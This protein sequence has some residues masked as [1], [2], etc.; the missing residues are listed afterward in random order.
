MKLD[1]YR[2]IAEPGEIRAI[3]R[4][5]YRLKGRSFIHVNATSFGG[6]VAE[7]LHRILPIIRELDI[8]MQ[9]KVIKGS[10]PFFDMTK[11]LHNSLQGKGK[12]ITKKMWELY[13]ETNRRNAKKLDLE[14]DCVLIHDPQPAGLI[15]SRK[16]GVWIWRCHID[17]STPDLVPWY[18]LKRHIEKYDASVFSVSTFAQS[19]PIHQ[20]MVP[21][22]IDPLSEKNIDLDDEYVNSV[23]E[24][25]SIP[26][27]KPILLQVS[28]F[29]PWKDPV[30]VIEA[31]RMVKKYTDCRLILAGGTA[32]DDPEGEVVLEEV[33]EAAGDDPDIHVILL[34]PSSDKE[35][36]ALQRA[37]DIVI[38]KSL[39]EGFG[40]V[41]AEAMWKGKPVIGSA[42]GGIPL[43]IVDGVNGFLVHSIEGTAY[44]IRQLLHNP[45]LA[46]VMGGVGREHI[47]KN[48]LITR[49]IRDYL[50]MWIAMENSRQKVIYI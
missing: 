43:Q 24:K 44:R 9:W 26:K 2:E 30:G 21:P 20:F 48:F 35:I 4:L 39:R 1:L 8:D 41:V 11:N 14:G 34:P 31:Y 7:L 13:E 27:D 37:A 16:N 46:W 25:L 19:I 40:L 32:A 23:L 36:N 38:Q 18:F 22:S 10:K 50:A 49:H 6:G 47:R 29:D 3:E 12:T 17:I 28:R 45:T 5:A 15:S 33:K 42:V